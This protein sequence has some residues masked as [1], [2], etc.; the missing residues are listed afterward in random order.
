LKAVAKKGAAVGIALERTEGKPPLWHPLSL[1]V[2]QVLRDFSGGF[3][4]R[5][6]HLPQI[7]RTR[8]PARPPAIMS[9]RSA[10]PPCAEDKG[11]MQKC[12]RY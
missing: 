10:E 12:R 4:D 8:S 3:K 9:G 6:L 2:S 5:A 11:S 7:A 1:A